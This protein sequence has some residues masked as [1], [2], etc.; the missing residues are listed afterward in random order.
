MLSR[1]H[2]VPSRHE[3]GFHRFH[4]VVVLLRA[5]AEVFLY[6]L[7]NANQ[8]RTGQLYVVLVPGSLHVTRRNTSNEHLAFEPQVRSYYSVNGAD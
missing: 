5:H 4:Y 3:I 2:V 7:A 1:L 6:V 8:P